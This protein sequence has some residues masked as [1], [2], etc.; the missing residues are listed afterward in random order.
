MHPGHGEPGVLFRFVDC[1][2]HQV[3]STFTESS[4]YTTQLTTL[5]ILSRRSCYGRRQ[6]EA[7][8]FGVPKLLAA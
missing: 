6:V 4:E 8:P 7:F 3:E 5:E 1:G 2:W